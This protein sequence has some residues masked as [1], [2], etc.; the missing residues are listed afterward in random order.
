[1]VFA[2]EEVFYLVLLAG[3]DVEAAAAVATFYLLK[4]IGLHY[5]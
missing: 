2:L 3:S 1:M 5:F 4:I